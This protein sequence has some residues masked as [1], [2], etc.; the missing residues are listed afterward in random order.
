MLSEKNFTLSLGAVC[1]SLSLAVC[2]WAQT[3]T[4][5]I[6]GTVTDSAGAVVA[7]AKVT[8]K[9]EAT[10]V[11]YTQTTT[12]SGLYAFPSVPVGAYTITVEMAGFK[13]VNKTGTVLEVGTPLVVDAALEVGQT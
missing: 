10:G 4:S 2:A 1:L 6:T 5:R 11:S 13:T 9:N 7:G 12:S 3:S 8:A